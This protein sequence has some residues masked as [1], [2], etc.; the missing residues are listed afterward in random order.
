MGYKV[1]ASNAS[2]AV[3][4]FEVNQYNVKQVE[5]ASWGVYIRRY[6]EKATATLE[7]TEK[8]ETT[9][10]IVESENRTEYPDSGILEDYWYEYKGIKEQND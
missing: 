8:G 1:S 4:K 6:Y 5:I 7:S 9:N 2:D 10:E 3:G